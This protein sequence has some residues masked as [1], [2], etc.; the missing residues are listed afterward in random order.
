MK[1]FFKALQITLPSLA[2]QAVRAG[3]RGT[4]SLEIG[5]NFVHIRNYAQ[6]TLI[7]SDTVDAVKPY[8][9]AALA[10]H[11][12]D[13]VDI[14]RGQLSAHQAFLNGFKPASL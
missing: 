11:Q 9:N 12:Y 2:A 3:T 14:D 10:R 8:R 13:V 4:G 6:V 7:G 5:Q 1:I